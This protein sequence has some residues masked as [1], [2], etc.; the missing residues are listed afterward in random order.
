MTPL[1]PHQPVLPPPAG[2]A[3]ARVRVHVFG[4]LRIERDGQPLTAR[5]KAPR[6]PLELLALLAAHGP[7]PLACTQVIDSLWPSLDANAPRASLDMAVSRLRRL[8]GAAAAVSVSD[9]HVRLDTRLVWTDVAAFE[10]AVLQHALG[11][12]AAALQAL[13][14]YSDALLGGQPLRGLLRLRRDQL[15][16]RLAWL[17]LDAGAALQRQGDSDSA[18][19]LYQHALE[20]DPLNEPLHRALIA[21]RLAQGEQAEARRSLQRCRDL[22]QTL[23][24]VAPAPAT[25]ALFDAPAAPDGAPPSSPSLPRGTAPP[26]RESFVASRL[27][28]QA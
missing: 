4:P 23:L 19:C 25:L 11:Q 5:G 1:R 9:G 8:L 3:S 24:G 12:P 21:T 17:A 15:A 14:L 28:R 18:C 26:S 7:R 10:A 20:R 2:P 22:L 13:S 16:Q 6:R 27:A